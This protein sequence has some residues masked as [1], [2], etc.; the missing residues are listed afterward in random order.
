MSHACGKAFDSTG[1]VVAY[2]EYDGYIALPTLFSSQEELNE[3]YKE[4]QP[5]VKCTCGKPSTSVDLEADYG[6]G[7][8]WASSICLNCMCITGEV[9]PYGSEINDSWADYWNIWP[10]EG[11]EKDEEIDDA[12]DPN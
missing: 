10:T 7:I 3:N 4:D 9:D 8:D 5:D 11:K 12:D 6:G 1:N 2:F